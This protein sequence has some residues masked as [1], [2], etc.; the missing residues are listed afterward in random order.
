MFYPV[1][2]DNYSR[3]SSIH[4]ILP[5]TPSKREIICNFLIHFSPFF[6]KILIIHPLSPKKSKTT[7]DI[8]TLLCYDKKDEII[9][10]CTYHP[11]CYIFV[12]RRLA[13]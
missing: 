5:P 1:I 4:A 13:L 10:E 6:V 9:E 11:N 8:L 2:S 12:I 3:I 7:L